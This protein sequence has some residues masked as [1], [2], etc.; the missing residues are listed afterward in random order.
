MMTIKVPLSPNGTFSFRANDLDKPMFLIDGWM[1]SVN[2]GDEHETFIGQYSDYSFIPGNDSPFGTATYRLKLKCEDKLPIISMEIPEIFTNYKVYLDNEKIA[3]N[4][5]GVI[6]NFPLEKEAELKVVVENYDHYY[7]G[8][9]Y[10]AAIG[11]AKA[12]NKLHYSGTLTY[13][14]VCTMA[15]MLALFSLVLFLWRDRSSL[16]FHFGLLSISTVLCCMHALVWRFEIQSNWL[17]AMEDAARIWILG[18]AVMV[19]ACVANTNKTKWI[20]TAY[21]VILLAAACVAI[22]VAFILPNRANLIHGYGYFMEAVSIGCWIV[23]SVVIGVSIDKVSRTYGGLLLAGCCTMGIAVLWNLL[24]TN[25]F[26]PIYTMWQIEWAA[27]ILTVLYALVII[28]HNGETLRENRRM[29]ENLETMVEERSRELSTMIEERKLFLSDMAHNLKSPIATIHGF[30]NLIQQHEIGLDDELLGYIAIIKDENMEM[31]KRVQALNFL[32]D[33]DRI[34]APKVEISVNKLLDRVEEFNLAAAEINGVHLVIS[35]LKMDKTLVAQKQKLLM[36]FEN[37][38]N[39]ALSFTPVEGTVTVQA[40]ALSDKIIFTV[41]DTGC[42]ITADKLPHIF[43]RFY[44]G[45]DDPSEGCGLG[46][47]IVKL[48]LDEL[49]GNIYVDSEV[50]VGTK[51]SIEIPLKK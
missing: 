31:Q 26:E 48:T 12:I 21:T 50:G 23:L 34:D 47:Y 15:V 6:V 19:A 27:Y 41:E 25:N 32:N 24:D 4:K 9:F 16:F 28:F 2:G 39:N 13:V 44:V 46:L 51:F 5:S 43:D 14:F 29:K 3:E 40:T 7:S 36:M 37:L 30:I 42:G 33:F 1:V 22:S 8:M 17:Y 38:I 11:T 49:G 18:E 10:P 35:R 45:R 20:R